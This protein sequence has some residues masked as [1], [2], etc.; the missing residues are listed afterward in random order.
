[1]SRPYFHTQRKKLPDQYGDSGAMA[2]MPALSH[3]ETIAEI[4]SFTGTP[5][6]SN[7]PAWAQ[8]LYDNPLVTI[9]GR[10]SGNPSADN[11]IEAFG[12]MPL[13]NPRGYGWGEAVFVDSARNVEG[14]VVGGIIR[15]DVL[16]IELTWNY[17]LR[18]D[19]QRIRSVPFYC[20]VRFYAPSHGEFV[21]RLM[22]KSDF[23]G[24]THLL[25]ASHGSLQLHGD[26]LIVPP[27]SADVRLALIEV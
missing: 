5:N 13:P 17:L 27:G 25:K 7:R 22:Y 6:L 9:T 23:T 16:K 4:A 12:P 20:R 10:L 2:I 18:E 19:V 24:G 14:Y 26:S 1:M 3:E 21:E 11:I 8:V 15:E